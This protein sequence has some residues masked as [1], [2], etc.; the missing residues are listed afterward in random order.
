MLFEVEH[1]IHIPY[2]DFF[3]VILSPEYKAWLES[4]LARV[5]RTV[6]KHEHTDETFRRTVIWKA[7]LPMRAQSFLR[8]P[9]LMVEDRQTLSLSDGSFEWEYVPNVA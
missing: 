6:V 1:I 5:D 2:K 4:K 8:V 3:K 9:H 7:D